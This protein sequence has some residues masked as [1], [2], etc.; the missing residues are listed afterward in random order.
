VNYEIKQFAAT[1][2]L[3]AAVNARVPRGRVGQYFGASLDKVW[4]FLRQNPGLRTDGHNYFL[5]YHSESD[6]Q[7]VSVD[8]GVQVIRSFDNDGDVRCVMTPEGEAV[9]VVHRGP[10]DQLHAAHTFIHDWCRNNNR[11][12]GDFSWELY[13]DWNNDVSKLE[14]TVVYLLQS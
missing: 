3:I 10:Y 13:G 4:Q 12:I 9:S 8:F 7:F 2:E 1:P 11:M 6:A 5:Y 14:T